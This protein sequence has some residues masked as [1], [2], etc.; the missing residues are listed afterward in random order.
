M[1]G[2]DRDQALLFK[3]LATLRTDAP[4]FQNV[5]ELEWRGPGTGFAEWTE[6]IGDKRLLERSLKAQATFSSPGP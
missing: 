1:L 6:R 3:H 4:L 5:D 2:N